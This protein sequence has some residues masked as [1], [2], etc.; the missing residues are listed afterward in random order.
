MKA[1]QE[2]TQ[3]PQQE[4]I[5]RVEQESSSGGEAT[6]VDNRSV[7]AVQRKLRSAMG[8]SGSEDS[9]NLIQRKNNTGL[10]DNLKSGIENLSG[11]SMDD[12]KVHYNSSKPAQL[13]AHAYAQGTDIH[14]APGQEKHLPHE[15]WHVVQQKQGRVKPTKQLKSKVNINDDAGLEKE[16]D[17]MGAKS[18][19]ASGSPSGKTFGERVSG[20][21]TQNTSVIQTKLVDENDGY[22]II[23][24]T[25]L[26]DKFEKGSR[27][28]KLLRAKDKEITHR[29]NRF[30]IP[31]LERTIQ[32]L[33]NENKRR[34]IDINVRKAN[35]ERLREL[36]K[37]LKK[38]RAKEYPKEYYNPLR[39]ALKSDNPMFF[40]IKDVKDYLDGQKVPGLSRLSA[41]DIK[42][43]NDVVTPV[44]EPIDALRRMKKNRE[45][46]AAKSAGTDAR[47]NVP[48]R[49]DNADVRLLAETFKNTTFFYGTTGEMQNNV[50][51]FGNFFA[52]V[53]AAK[54]K[55][56]GPNVGSYSAGMRNAGFLR[57]QANAADNGESAQM[58]DMYYGGQEFETW[59]MMANPI[60]GEYI[61]KM[62]GY[63][64]DYDH[65][66]SMDTTFRKNYPLGGGNWENQGWSANSRPRNFLL[67]GKK[68]HPDENFFKYLYLEGWD[69][70]I[71]ATMEISRIIREGVQKFGGTI[72]FEGSEV[73]NQSHFV[74]AKFG[75]RRDTNMEASALLPE[76]AAQPG[77]S[78]VGY[79]A[80]ELVFHWLGE[81]KTPTR[82]LFLKHWAYKAN[83]TNAVEDTGLRVS[84]YERARPDT[85]L[86]DTP[87]NWFWNFPPI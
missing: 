81:E 28:Y 23:T 48:V 39:E 11:Y 66:E 71:S 52:Q 73:T 30:S 22:K 45:K 36:E 58:M 37:T 77:K 18:I 47:G 67:D 25:D 17:V 34:G 15:A 56:L 19:Q 68:D 72:V 2:N 38:A 35:N 44:G 16:A 53:K 80:G 26:Y 46:Y 70:D 60:I 6:I 55:R 9:T 59:H 51:R 87:V 13:Q 27:Y 7:I 5:Q 64:G 20:A 79:G 3:E 82:K 74:A 40:T 63:A 10:P 29:V 54:T 83:Y 31:K 43:A 4:A 41:N 57:A 24:I 50:Y 1:S 84:Y 62:M 65:T 86:T 21:E 69:P 75:D 42:G 49:P 76:F 14:L 33:K 85:K 78:R 61:H 8:G 12:V 32:K